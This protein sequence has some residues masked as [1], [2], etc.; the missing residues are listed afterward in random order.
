MTAARG[1]NDNQQIVGWG[2]HNGQARGFLWQVGGSG[3]TDLGLLPGATSSYPKAINQ[4]GQV[5]GGTSTDS[6]LGLAFLWT[7]PGPP[8]GRRQR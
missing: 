1:I 5:G 7:S 2:T 8:S 4:T 3:I 6:G